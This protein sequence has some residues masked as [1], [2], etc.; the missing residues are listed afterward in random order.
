MAF[1]VSFLKIPLLSKQYDM[2][3]QT[4]IHKS[5]VFVPISG[6]K[7]RKHVSLATED[8]RPAIDEY[9]EGIISGEWPENLSFVSYDDFLAYLKSQIKSDKKVLFEF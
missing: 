9:P 1:S 3:P 6:T 7:S 2:M 5:S 8:M 4:P